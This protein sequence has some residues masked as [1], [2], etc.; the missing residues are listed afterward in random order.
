[1]NAPESITVPPIRFNAAFYRTALEQHGFIPTLIHFPDKLALWCYSLEDGQPMWHTQDLRGNLNDPA[2]A[3]RMLRV[4]LEGMFHR[5]VLEQRR[6]GYA[7]LYRGTPQGI[8][9]LMAEQSRR[10]TAQGGTT[11]RDTDSYP[12]LSMLA[13]PQPTL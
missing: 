9:E 11:L 5:L 8:L 2:T 6:T 3:G 10:I 12:G 13:S 1:M 4:L 7:D